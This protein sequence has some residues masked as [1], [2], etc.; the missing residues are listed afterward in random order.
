M[1]PDQAVTLDRLRHQLGTQVTLA[2]RARNTIFDKATSYPDANRQRAL[3]DLLGIY[4]RLFERY[5]DLQQREN[6][7]SAAWWQRYFA[8]VEPIATRASEE[9]FAFRHE[10]LKIYKEA[11]RKVGFDS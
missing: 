1:E 9:P 10:A 11:M 6:L 2:E 8:R 3:Y 5:I 4:R 7:Y